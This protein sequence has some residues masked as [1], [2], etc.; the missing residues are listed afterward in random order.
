[1]VVVHVM[2]VIIVA[3]RLVNLDLT[4]AAWATRYGLRGRYAVVAVTAMLPRYVVVA[5]TAL[6]PRYAIVA[7]TT[8]AHGDTETRERTLHGEVGATNNRNLSQIC[9][10]A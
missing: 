10:L 7:G 4:F 2:V 6:L 1:M 9:C 8:D 3:R 5:G